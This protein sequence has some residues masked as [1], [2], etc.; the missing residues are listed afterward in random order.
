MGIIIS[1]FIVFLIGVPIA[2]SLG[3]V[4]V[5]EILVDELPITVVIQKMFTGVDS[6]ALTA[7]P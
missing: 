3:I 7:I 4:S 6:I 1:L 5:T 2:F